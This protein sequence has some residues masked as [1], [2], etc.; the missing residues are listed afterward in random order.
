MVLSAARDEY[1]EII[2]LQPVK[3]LL[4]MNPMGLSA[5]WVDYIEIIVTKPVK[6]LLGINPWALVPLGTTIL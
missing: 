1:F 4:D 2:A 3:K 5:A 6:K